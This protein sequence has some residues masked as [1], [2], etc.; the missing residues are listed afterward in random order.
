MKK[1]ASGIFKD[2]RSGKLDVEEDPRIEQ[3]LN[4]N[5]QE[6]YNLTSKTSPADYAYMLL[7]LTKNMQ[8]KNKSQTFGN[9]YSGKYIQ[10]EISGARPE[11]AHPFRPLSFRKHGKAQCDTWMPW[12]FFYQYIQEGH[13]F[14]EYWSFW[15]CVEVQCPSRP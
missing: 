14:A 8:G 2:I 5:I 13:V 7:T 1:F 6:K 12:S 11:S 10:A 9:W 4:P 15:T 3:C